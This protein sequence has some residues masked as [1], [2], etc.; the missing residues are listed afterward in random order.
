MDLPSSFFRLPAAL[1]RLGAAG[2]APHYLLLL[3][4]IRYDRGDGGFDGKRRDRLCGG[5]IKLGLFGF[6]VAALLTFGHDDSPMGG[7]LGTDKSEV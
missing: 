2:V 7:P 6:F 5:F 1:P 4:P 3:V